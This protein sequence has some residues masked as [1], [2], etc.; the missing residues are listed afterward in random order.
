VPDGALVLG[1]LV[2][3][4]G[5][6]PAAR[7]LSAVRTGP[8]TTAT[9]GAAPGRVIAP[10][11]PDQGPAGAGARPG[12]LL[13]SWGRRLLDHGQE[14]HLTRREFELLEYL[15][16]HPGRVFTRGQ[17]LTAVWGAEDVRFAPPRTVDVHVARLRRKLASHARSLQTLR[18]VGYRWAPHAAAPVP[19]AAPGGIR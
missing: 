6:G 16:A 2:T 1:V 12:L 15:T 13:D 3:V 19:G 10:H 4:P 7:Q 9:P 17:L 8:G 11:L 18:G 14:V 5:P